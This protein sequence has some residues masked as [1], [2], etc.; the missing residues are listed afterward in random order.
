MVVGELERHMHLAV[1]VA[2]MENANRM[3]SRVYY[4]TTYTSTYALK[5]FA[6]ES[7]V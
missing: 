1:V 4:L 3:A 7:S 2:V 5:A 6:L